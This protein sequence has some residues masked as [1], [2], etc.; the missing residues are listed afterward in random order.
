MTSFV[1]SVLLT[2][3][4]CYKLLL[5][6]GT[7]SYFQQGT[8]TLSLCFQFLNLYILFPQRNLQHTG[9]L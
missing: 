6:Y 7:Q 4:P 8:K 1:N 2:E 3:E 5:K 9:E